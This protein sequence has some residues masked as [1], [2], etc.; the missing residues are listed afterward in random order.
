LGKKYKIKTFKLCCNRRIKNQTR[1]ELESYFCSEL[2]AAAYQV[3][4]LLDKDLPPS[5]FWPRSFSSKKNSVL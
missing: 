3:M 2:V 5:D 4:G 1:I